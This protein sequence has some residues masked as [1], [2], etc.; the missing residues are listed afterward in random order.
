M[1]DITF[2]KES[3]LSITYQIEQFGC[4]FNKVSI[5]MFS[6]NF[7]LLNIIIIFYYRAIELLL[8]LQDN[9]YDYDNYE[10]DNSDNDE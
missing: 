8:S 2:A 5:M 7:Y 9:S 10:S 6:F 3:T 1:H 4:L